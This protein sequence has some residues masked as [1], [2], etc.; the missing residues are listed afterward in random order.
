[1]PLAASSDRSIISATVRRSRP[2]HPYES[3]SQVVVVFAALTWLLVGSST[4]EFSDLDR[5]WQS[6]VRIFLGESENFYPQILEAQPTVGPV[7]VVLYQVLGVVLLLNVVIA[8]LLEVGSARLFLTKA[9]LLLLSVVLFLLLL[10][11]LLLLPLLLLLLL[12]AAVVVAAAAAS[13]PLLAVPLLVLAHGRSSS[14]SLQLHYTKADMTD[15]KSRFHIYF[16]S[17]S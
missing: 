1:M 5:A 11:L 10:L 9:K 4:F 15:M 3:P 16:L 6:V 13:V 8:I 17:M 14:G 12:L 7:V 2:P